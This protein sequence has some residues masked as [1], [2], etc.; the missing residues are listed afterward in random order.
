MPQMIAKPKA[1]H[2]MALILLV[3]SVCINYIDRGNLGVAAKSIEADLLL[4]QR[5]LGLLL[6]GFFWTY[7]LLQIAAGKVIDRYNVNWVYAVGFFLWSGCTAATGLAT[8][9]YSIFLMRLLI[10]VGESVAYPS[11]SKII[12]ATFPEGLRG[13]ANA[14]IDAG[15]KVGPALGVLVGVKLV[16]WLNWR[17]MFFAIGV[18]SL[19][20]LIPWT[21]IVP[22]LKVRVLENV[23][24]ERELVLPSYREILS[25]RAVWGTMVG[26]FGANY[27]WYF[28]L[29]WLPYYFEHER[30]YTHDKLAFLGSLPFWF[31]AASSMSAGLAADAIIRRGATAARL[32]Q[33]FVVFG[34]CGCCVFMAAS[35]L[36]ES[37]TLSLALLLVASLVYGLFSSN[38]WALTQSLAGPDVAGKW[39]GVENCVGNFA[40]VVAAYITGLVLERTH[41]FFFAFAIAC[42]V[43]IFGAWGFWFLIGKTQRVQWS[44]EV[45]VPQT[46][47]SL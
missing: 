4:S 21:V 6:G 19:I 40:G 30:H 38:H 15:S 39:T 24:S 26:L 28:F 46:V 3:I 42:G 14:M 35:I 13:T 41:V 37:A 20:W 45:T 16:A 10:G 8:G 25:K 29:T 17:G 9:F 34:L 11:Y 33:K 7:S 27:T 44:F 32:R 1:I 23:G 36:V 18:V 43:L 5:Q 2:W 12:A 22:R 31:V 47:D